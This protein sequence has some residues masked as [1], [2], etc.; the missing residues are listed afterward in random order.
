MSVCKCTH[1]RA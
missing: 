1:Q